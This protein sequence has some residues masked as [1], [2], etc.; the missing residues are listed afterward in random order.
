MNT[1]NLATNRENWKSIDGYSNYEVSWWGRV[2]N[3]KTGRILKSGDNGYG[4]LI[5]RLSKD[6]NGKT[7]KIHQ[8]VASDRVQNSD[9]KICVDHIDG[10]KTN[11]HHGNLRFA[12]HSENS[13]NMKHSD[14][15]SVYKGIA[16]NKVNNKWQAQLRMNGKQQHLG[17]FA[18]E[19]EAAESYNADAVEFYK[20]FAKVN[21]FTD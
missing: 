15:S 11:N 19:R 1:E 17:C 10:C 20:E 18:S 9:G 16:Y 3:S 21:I 8:L 14:G 12:T 2:R 4:Y 5:V 6:S 7:H 13:R